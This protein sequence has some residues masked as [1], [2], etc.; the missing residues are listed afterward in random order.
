M[1]SISGTQASLQI[2]DPTTAQLWFCGKEMYRDGKLVADYLGRFENSK[3][4]V[5][6]SKRGDGPPGREPIMTEEQRK[7]LMLHAY[8]KQEELK[9]LEQDDDDHYLNSEWADSGNLKRT[10]HGLNSISWKPSCL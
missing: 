7:E 6:I 8:R 10:V 3:V 9:K 4:V 5:K 2:I 1:E